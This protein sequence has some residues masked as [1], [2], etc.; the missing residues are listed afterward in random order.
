M[1]LSSDGVPR[2]QLVV[3]RL[4]ALLDLERI[5]EDIFRGV[6]PPESPVRVFG[7]QVAGQALV[8]A[9]RTVPV[10]RAV[11]SLV[12]V[13]G[14]PPA[15]PGRWAEALVGPL[16]ERG[17]PVLRASAEDFLRPASLRLEHGRTDADAFYSDRLDTG[18]LSRELLGAGGSGRVLPRWWD[19][20]ADR[21]ARASYVMVAPGT[22]LLID[23]TMLLGLGLAAELVV[24]LH[25]SAAALRRGTPTELAWTLPA[26]A[27]YAEEVDPERLADVVVRPPSGR[28]PSSDSHRVVIRDGPRRRC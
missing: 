13:D 25:L 23:G 20:T 22:V 4:V 16:Q 11:H 27:R 10:E 3:D 5:E 28:R 7:G 21:S 15:E 24:H 12:L 9:G 17:R 18:A 6:S 1:P 26:Y 2:G 14:A 8:A 19:V